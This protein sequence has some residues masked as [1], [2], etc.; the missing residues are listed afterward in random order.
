MPG[1]AEV[2]LIGLA[3][4]VGVG[5]FIAAGGCFG[6]GSFFKFPLISFGFGGSSFIDMLAKPGGGTLL[7]LGSTGNGTSSSL[8]SSV[9]K[10][11]CFLNKADGGFEPLS[12]AATAA[13]IALSLLPDAG[14]DGI[15]ILDLR[16]L[17]NSFFCCLNNSRIRFLSSIPNLGTCSRETTRFP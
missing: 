14:G 13:A 15:V 10:E 4:G 2:A 7:L 1:G 16:C 12:S 6:L 11:D 9:S 5:R 8:L 17:R 3:R